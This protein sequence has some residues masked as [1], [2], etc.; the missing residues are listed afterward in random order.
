MAAADLLIVDNDERIRE[1]MAWFLERRGYRVRRAGSYREGRAC[2]LERWPDLVLAD[3]EL[4]AESGRE[5]LPRLAAEGLLPPT[6]VVSGYLDAPTRVELE[7]LAPVVALLDKP[8]DLER[9]EAAV[10]AALERGVRAG[11]ARPAA[12]PPPA[13]TTEELEDDE[14]WIEIVPLEPGGGPAERA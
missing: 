3:V 10:R 14:G 6:I 1:L 8:C 5:E 12:D 9:L 13:A 11:P 4:G 2:L 7:A